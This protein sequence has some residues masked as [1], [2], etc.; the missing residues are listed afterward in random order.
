LVVDGQTGYLVRQG[1]RSAF[2]RHVWRLLRQP[3]LAREMGANAKDR[4]AR[5][6]SAERMIQSYMRLY[7]ELWWKIAHP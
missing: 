3:E 2:A 4:A 7:D 5:H 1:D 6:F